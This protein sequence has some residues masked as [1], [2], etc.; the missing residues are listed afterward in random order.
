MTAMNGRPRASA[1]RIFSAASSCFFA[2]E[3]AS[4]SSATITTGIPDVAFELGDPDRN[5]AQR[6][7]DQD[8]PR[9]QGQNQHAGYEGLAGA[10]AH[11]QQDARSPAAN[12]P[13][14]TRTRLF[15]A[16]RAG[17]HALRNHD[18]RFT[19]HRA[20]SGPLAVSLAALPVAST[21]FVPVIRLSNS[22]VARIV[23]NL[24]VSNRALA[25][26]AGSSQA[27][28]ALLN[29]PPRRWTSRRSAK[30][31]ARSGRASTPLRVALSNTLLALP[32]T[33]ARFLH[34]SVEPCG[35]G[36]PVTDFVGH[37][38]GAG[39]S[40]ELR[41]STQFHDQVR[42][43]VMVA[44]LPVLPVRSFGPFGHTLPLRLHCHR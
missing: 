9:A 27:R 13:G 44:V 5:D 33:A 19:R 34:R 26:V 11:G 4:S 32:E 20:P 23:R 42:K 25:S 29:C 6:A 1:S 14:R 37:R 21:A 31:A 36:L 28:A 30:E 22:G 10:H 18:F 7:D 40:A 41:Q 15:G 2:T 39:R 35:D 17:E 3:P 12:C 43:T 16:A 8:A 24:L 38:Q